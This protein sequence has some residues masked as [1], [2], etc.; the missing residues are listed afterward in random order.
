MR[1]IGILFLA[2][3]LALAGCEG[4]MVSAPASAVKPAAPPVAAYTGDRSPLTRKVSIGH[5][6]LDDTTGSIRE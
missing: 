6:V 2:L 1:S 3:P 4:G 5:E